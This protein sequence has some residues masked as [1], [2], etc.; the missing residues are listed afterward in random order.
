M[1]VR[2]I[3]IKDAETKFEIPAHVVLKQEQAICVKNVEVMM[4]EPITDEKYIQRENRLS[5]TLYN[6]YETIREEVKDNLTINAMQLVKVIKP[7]LRKYPKTTKQFVN[8]R[9]LKG[10][11]L[12]NKN[13]MTSHELVLFSPIIENAVFDIYQIEIKSGS[14]KVDEPDKTYDEDVVYTFIRNI[15]LS[16]DNEMAEELKSA[17]EEYKAEEKERER[18]AAEAEK[19]EPLPEL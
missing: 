10:K 14:P 9:N 2:E 13:K 6:E 15:K 12:F 4:A 7:I 18:Q 1:K 17:Y 19:N 8:C 5:L 16:D 11:C 3:K